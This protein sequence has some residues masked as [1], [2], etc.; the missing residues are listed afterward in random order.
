MLQEIEIDYPESKKSFGYRHF[1]IQRLE[2]HL[3]TETLK[4]RD[5]KIDWILK[6]LLCKDLTIVLTT[7]CCYPNSR[8]FQSLVQRSK[9]AIQRLEKPLMTKTITND[10]FSNCSNVHPIMDHPSDYLYHKAITLIPLTAFIGGTPCRFS[11]IYA[12]G[13]LDE[14]TNSLSV[15]FIWSLSNI[16]IYSN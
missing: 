3:D 7:K 13:L 6:I 11:T 8:N 9:L 10:I 5:L 14:H 2:N 4:C 16:R 1:A 15:A 12:F